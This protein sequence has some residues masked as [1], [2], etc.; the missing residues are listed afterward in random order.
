MR[1]RVPTPLSGTGVYYSYCKDGVNYYVSG[2]GLNFY[3]KGSSGNFVAASGP[4]D[5]ISEPWR[6]A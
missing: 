6:C 1:R 5:P 2:D 4:A 3:V